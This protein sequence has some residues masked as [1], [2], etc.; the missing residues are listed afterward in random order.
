MHW[1]VVYQHHGLNF[2][3]M[4]ALPDKKMETVTHFLMEIFAIQGAPAIL[5]SD[6]GREF[7]NG[8][9]DELKSLWVGLQIVHGRA[10]HS[11]S[12]GGVERLNRTV[13]DMVF[14]HIREN[15]TATWVK[16]VPFVQFAYNC[17]LHEGTKKSPYELVYGSRPRIG[18]ASLGLPEADLSNLVEEMECHPEGPREQ[19]LLARLKNLGI[20]TDAFCAR[21]SDEGDQETF[22]HIP[23]QQAQDTDGQEE[24][25]GTDHEHLPDQTEFMQ[26]DF[27]DSSVSFAD[28]MRQTENSVEYLDENPD[29]AA[30]VPP[31]SVAPAETFYFGLSQQDCETL[32][33]E[34]S[35]QYTIDMDGAVVT[36]SGCSPSEPQGT[37]A[38]PFVSPHIKKAPCSSPPQ[39]CQ[40]R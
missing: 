31:P 32:A 8:V 26:P 16:D 20:G 1:L 9:I 7:V 37:S 27:D 6:N 22:Q 13:Q 5:Q 25:K 33:S 14:K 19:V 23:T 17:R 2:A 40:T 21:D 39:P 11:Q 38:S 36:A 4:R 18:L 12:Q 24:E 3:Y 28:L 29:A 35:T 15:Q 30:F 34:G 10:R